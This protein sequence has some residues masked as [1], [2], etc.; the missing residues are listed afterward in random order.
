MTKRHLTAKTTV[1][2]YRLLGVKTL[3]K[4]LAQSRDRVIAEVARQINIEAEAALKHCEEQQA[5][6]QKRSNRGKAR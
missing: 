1:E 2:A 6:R 4:A 3:A 5:N